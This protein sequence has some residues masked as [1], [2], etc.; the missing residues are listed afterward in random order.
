MKLIKTELLQLIEKLDENQLR[1]VL[2]FI[3]KLFFS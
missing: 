2:S 3:E 1:L